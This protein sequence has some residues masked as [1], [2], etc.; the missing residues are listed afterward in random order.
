MLTPRKPCSA[1][2]SPAVPAVTV[3]SR[4]ALERQAQGYYTEKRGEAIMGFLIPNLICWAIW[5]EYAK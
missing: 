3:S 5:F 2:C 1:A 4:P